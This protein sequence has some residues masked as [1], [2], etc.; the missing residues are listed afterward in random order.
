MKNLGEI[1]RFF[2]FLKGRKAWL[3]F[4]DDFDSIY[5]NRYDTKLKGWDFQI[6]KWNIYFR[7]LEDQ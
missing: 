5:S 6:H 3:I 7:Q 4:I 2:E 1:Q